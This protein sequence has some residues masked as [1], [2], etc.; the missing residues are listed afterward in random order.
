MFIHCE[1][2]KRKA[3]RANLPEPWRHPESGTTLSEYFGSP[4]WEHLGAPK[5]NTYQHFN[6]FLRK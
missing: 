6:T 1:T 3:P 2:Q 4:T 5:C